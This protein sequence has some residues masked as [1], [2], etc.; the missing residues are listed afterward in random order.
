MKGKKRRF[1]PPT[2]AK[3]W[4]RLGYRHGYDKGYNAG[5]DRGFDQGYADAKVKGGAAEERFAG[6]SIII[7]SYNQQAYLARCIESIRAHTRPPYELIVIDNASQDGTRDY[8]HRLDGPVRVW[9]SERNLGFAGAVNQGLRL[10]RGTTLVILNN[11]T[12]VTEGWLNNLLACVNSDPAFGLVGPVTNYIGGEQQ[13]QTNYGSIEEMQAFAAA[14]N[15][16]DPAKWSPTGRLV[17]FCY[18]LRR[19]TF[20][21]LGYFDEGFEIG[22]CED[23]DYALRTRLLGLELIIAY[24]TFI[25]HFGSVSMKALG[26]SFDEVYEK[27]M[28]FYSEKWGEP[29]GLVDEVR[30]KWGS[31]PLRMNDF[32]PTHALVQGPPGVFWLEGEVLHPTD[33]RLGLNATRLSQVELRNWQRGERLTAEEVESRLHALAHATDS[34]WVDG[35][36]VRAPDGRLFQYDRG[37]LRRFQTERAIQAWRMD[38]RSAVSVAAEDLAQWPEGRPIVPPPVL[39]SDVL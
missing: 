5:Y 8:L 35:T 28:R 22:N 17:G 33:S 3:S 9:C 26:S 20:E 16:S 37:T 31:Q 38:E 15:R 6:T 34:A 7:P 13:I 4:R 2:A 12:I 19:D 27:N 1:V 30:R 24:D 25:H 36:L 11:D 32:Y 10:A 29:H 21:R 39:K 18:M 23:D 14:Y